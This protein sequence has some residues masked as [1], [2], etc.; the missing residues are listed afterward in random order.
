MYNIFL[1]GTC[2]D[3]HYFDVKIFNWCKMVLF[4]WLF[5]FTVWTFLQVESIAVFVKEPTAR[6]CYFMVTIQVDKSLSKKKKKK[7]NKFGLWIASECLLW[8]YFDTLINIMFLLTNQWISHVK[9]SACQKILLTS[10]LPNIFRGLIFILEGQL[11]LTIFYEWYGS[12]R[13]AETLE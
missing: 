10:P 6:A 9:G 13:V 11:T 7:K 8:N 2:F 1:E 4:V 12:V 5:T 3:C